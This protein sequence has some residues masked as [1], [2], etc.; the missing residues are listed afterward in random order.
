MSKTSKRKNF[1]E[2]RDKVV[3]DPG[4]RERVERIE[5]AYDAFLNLADLREARGITQAQ[6]A[7]MLGVSQPA[8][9]KIEH[10][11]VSVSTLIRYAQALGG[12]LELKVSFPEHPEH[13]IA[14]DVVSDREASPA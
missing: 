5:E 10:G 4:R 11:N 2:L 1:N 3:A 7:G 13:E 8:V 14:V 6:L 12:H 9:S